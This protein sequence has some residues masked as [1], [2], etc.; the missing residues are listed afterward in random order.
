MSLDAA[1]LNND[2]ATDLYGMEYIPQTSSRQLAVFLGHYGRQF[3]YLFTP[4]ASNFSNIGAPHAAADFDGTGHWALAALND[5]NNNND[6][7][8]VYFLNVGTPGVTIVTGP[9]P[10][11]VSGW[12]VGPVVGN[13]NG[14][15][16]PDIAVV[17]SPSLQSPTSTIA[18]RGV[19]SDSAAAS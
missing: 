10:A 12:Q 19:S 9:S 3:G 13:F 2:A 7:Q 6:G 16:K 18:A 17:S 8:M 15:T 14:D 1:D 5:P 4:L 11:G